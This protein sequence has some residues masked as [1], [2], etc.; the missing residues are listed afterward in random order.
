MHPGV[1]GFD[2]TKGE[3]PPLGRYPVIGDGS[4]AVHSSLSDPMKTRSGSAV[5]VAELAKEMRF[6]DV[7][8]ERPPSIRSLKF[9][10]PNF[11]FPQIEKD[12]QKPIPAWFKT[13]FQ[14]SLFRG[15]YSL[16][17]HHLQSRPDINRSSAGF[18]V[19]VREAHDDFEPSHVPLH[20][21]FTCKYFINKIIPA[22]NSRS[23]CR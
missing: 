19:R 5:V 21:L 7:D 10:L 13:M 23:T 8:G 20:L 6:T 14:M 3:S 16:K 12:I 9:L 18:A 17:G 22:L 2:L 15:L 1:S 11:V 4:Q